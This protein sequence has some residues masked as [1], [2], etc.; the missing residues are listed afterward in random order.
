MVEDWIKGSVIYNGD[1]SIENL[2][3]LTEHE[4]LCVVAYLARRGA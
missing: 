1:P 3:A 4:C 2:V